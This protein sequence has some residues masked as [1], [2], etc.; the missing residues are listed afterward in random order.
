MIKLVENPVYSF[1]VFKKNKKTKQVVFKS[2]EALL[3]DM[4]KHPDWVYHRN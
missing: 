3:R 1:T 4:A 2:I